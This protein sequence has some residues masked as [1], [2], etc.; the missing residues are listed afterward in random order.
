MSAKN[1]PNPYALDV[2]QFVDSPS[3]ELAVVVHRETEAK[4]ALEALT[5]REW[6]GPLQPP[7]NALMAGF[8]TYDFSAIKPWGEYAKT[9]DV[10]VRC[11][12]EL[13]GS[14]GDVAK[15]IALELGPEN[16]EA[17]FWMATWLQALDHADNIKAQMQEQTQAIEKAKEK[18]RQD[19]RSGGLAKNKQKANAKAFVRAEWAL[20]QDA[21]ARNK[22]A[23]ARDYVGRIRH[24]LGVE[25][26]HDFVSVKCLGGL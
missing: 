24:E 11:R 22:R 2:T 1:K 20:H 3:Y 5:S 14:L 21:Y 26:T 16:S 8:Q 25:V 18:A 19:R 23:F 6:H 7:R 12:E 17:L 15:R 13:G 10:L 4:R 9:F